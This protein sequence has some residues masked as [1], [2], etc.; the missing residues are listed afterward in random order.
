MIAG[1]LVGLGATI[2]LWQRSSS[3]HFGAAPRY[4]RI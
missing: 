1:W 4:Y 3:R 2:L